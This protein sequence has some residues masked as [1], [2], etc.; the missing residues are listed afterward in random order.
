MIPTSTKIL[1]VEDSPGDARLI[2]ELL[3]SAHGHRFSVECVGGLAAGLER[4]CDDGI[5]VVLLDLGLPDSRG[6]DTFAQV[7]ALSPGIPIVVLTG[8]DDVELALRA[9]GA[10][11]QDYLVKGKVDAEAL[12]RTMRY[13]IERKRAEEAL[14]ASEMRFRS[15]AQSATDAIILADS[16]GRIFFWNHAA[17]NVFGY[18]EEE[19]LGNPLTM[20]MPERYRDAQAKELTRLASTGESN[21]L[22]M[23]LELEGLR[24]DGGEFPLEMSVGTWEVGKGMCYVGIVR[25]ITERKRAEDALRKSR[26]SLRNLA[27]RLHAV[28][29]AERALVAREMHDELGQA[30]T[31]LKMDV[32]WLMARLPKSRKPV[33]ERLHSM[34]SLVD[35]M[36]ETV[37]ELSSRLRPAVLDDLG[38]AAAVEWEVHEFRSRADLKGELNLEAG[39]LALERDRDTAV[40]RI[41]QE[42]LTNV[43]RHAGASRVDVDLAVRDGEVVLE[44]KDDGRGIT[45]DELASTESIGL[46]GMRERAMDLGGR[47]DIGRA[48]ERGTVVKLRMPT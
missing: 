21:I 23:T 42:A 14:Q 6:F 5:D 25:D 1:L 30:L 43:A 9:V 24:K 13:A 18:T 36:V 46:I 45:E 17:H 37:R 11:A 4:L 10:G 47:V 16:G 28:R 44:V 12:S 34:V 15:V 40:F 39:E 31:G 29:E 3:S 22:G 19:V 35:G 33:V 8:T 32:S 38:L 26:Q 7:Q 2:R 48:A 41:L 27:A 20:L